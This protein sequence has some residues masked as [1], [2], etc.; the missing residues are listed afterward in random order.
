M[1]IDARA[2]IEEMLR[3]KRE[4]ISDTTSSVQNIKPNAL[5]NVPVN[6]SA[7]II[8]VS[9]E[10]S[11]TSA[12]SKINQMLRQRQLEQLDNNQTSQTQNQDTM[13]N[14]VNST[15]AISSVIQTANEVIPQVTA[16]PRYGLCPSCLADL[17]IIAGLY[18]CTRC[19]Q[20]FV[21]RAAQG[22]LINCS[23][24]PYG[25][26]RCCELRFP[27]LKTQGNE[28]LICS[29]S[30][31][32][33]LLSAKGYLRASELPFGLCSCCQAPNPLIAKPDRTICCISSNEE[34]IKNIDG[35]VVRRPLE[36]N[37]Q[38]N[39]DIEGALNQGMAAFYYGGFI[40]GQEPE[41]PPAQIPKRQRRRWF[42]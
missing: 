31:E 29:V 42:L 32:K 9:E 17:D 1:S 34:Y 19:S 12:L 18:A 2:K 21:R 3:R 33:Y 22:D 27:L 6:V 7:P 26:C 11:N 24:L 39:Q 37:L 5:V 35:T 13:I 41:P 23:D 36:V 40:G 30:Q 20:H 10:K 28:G 15:K 14:N 4:A 25:Y 38:T 16:K 8:N